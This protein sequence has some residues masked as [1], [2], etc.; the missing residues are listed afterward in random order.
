MSIP[1]I[2]LYVADYDADTA[3]LTLEEDGAYLRLLRLCWRTPGCSVPDD[4]RWI[5]RKLR[6]S[7]DDYYRVVEPII[8]EFFTRGLGRVFSPRLQYEKDRIEETAKKRADAGRK[9]GRPKTPLKTNDKYQSRAKAK[10]KQ[11]ELE[12]ELEPERDTYVSLKADIFEDWWEI[13]PRKIGKGAARKA[14]EKA[15]KATDEATLFLAM[16]SHADAMADKD[17]QFIPHPATWLNQERWTDEPEQR[18]QHH[19]SNLAERVA[20]RFG[21]VDSGTDSNSVVPL[22]PARRSAGSD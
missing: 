7:A 19:A 11:P 1:Y 14:F 15:F 6:V 16:K 8:D 5:M 22:L 17:P 2:P 20:A 10:Q 12:P 21:E 13:C 18:K 3:H 4:P 9:G